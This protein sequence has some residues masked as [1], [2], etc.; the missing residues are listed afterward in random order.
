M[1]R[2]PVRRCGNN[3]SAEIPRPRDKLKL[4]NQDTFS[5]QILDS[6][7]RP[8]GFQKPNPREFNFIQNSPMPSYRSKLSCEEPT[9]LIA[10]LASLKGVT[11]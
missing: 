2:R 8:L 1:R 6:K 9:D 10:Y 5:V 7:E 3:R 11:K 4:L